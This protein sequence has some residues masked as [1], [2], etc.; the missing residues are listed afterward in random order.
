MLAAVFNGPGEIEIKELE[1]PGIGPDEVLVKVEANT[2]CGTDVRILRGEKTKGVS[3]P[4]VLGHELA[5]RV[6]EVGGDVG[7]YEAGMRVVVSPGIPCGRCYP[8]KHDMEN[9]CSELR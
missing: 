6:A 1:T 8:C 5:G 7:G 3:R 4:G 9:M 2:V